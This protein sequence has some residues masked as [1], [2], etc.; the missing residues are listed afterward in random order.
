MSPDILLS[1]MHCYVSKFTYIIDTFVFR[2]LLIEKQVTRTRYKKRLKR[3]LRKHRP[4]GAVPLG[5]KL[6][7][8]RQEALRIVGEYPNISSIEFWRLMN[9]QGLAISK[10]YA[11]KLRAR[12]FRNWC[13][14]VLNPF[15]RFQA[16]F[17]F[18]L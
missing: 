12:V 9:K 10:D 1:C 11:R 2:S 5:R 13:K 6:E 14:M 18:L 16:Y 8:R 3:F 17:G 7:K 15:L 4:L